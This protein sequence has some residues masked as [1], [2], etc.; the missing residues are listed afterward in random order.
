MENLP[1]QQANEKTNGWGHKLSVFI[2]FILILQFSIFAIVAISEIAARES[3]LSVF[4]GRIATLKSE[5]VERNRTR[6]RIETSISAESAPTTKYQSDKTYNDSYERDKLLAKIGS[7]E[8]VKRSLIFLIAQGSVDPS[9]S[10]NT[11][12]TIE[13]NNFRLVVP[14]K[15]TEE[16]IERY[17]YEQFPKFMIAAYQPFLLLSSD[18]LLAIA[19]MACAAIGALIAALRVMV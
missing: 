3:V 13:S 19:I 12:L 17:R 14:D 11:I 8:E 7:Y 18:Q 2:S 10:L 4:T 16:A 9:F 6:T 1:S 15:K 5:F